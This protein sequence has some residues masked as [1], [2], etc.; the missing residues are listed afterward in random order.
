MATKTYG[1]TNASPTLDPNYA[2]VARSLS[3]A[4]LEEEILGRKGEPGYQAALVAELEQRG[5]TIPEPPA[6]A[7]REFD[8]D[9]WEQ[10]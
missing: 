9:E 1:Y 7:A 4:E 6:R 10:R 5:K 2:R 3:D 8:A